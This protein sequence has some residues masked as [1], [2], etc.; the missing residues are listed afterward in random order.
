MPQYHR[1]L[2]INVPISQGVV[3]KGYNIKTVHKTGQDCISGHQ[4]SSTQV[5]IVSKQRYKMVL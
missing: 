3:Y 5:Y 4:Q 1:V 2:Y